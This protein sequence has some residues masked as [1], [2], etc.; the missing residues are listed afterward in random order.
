VPFLEISDCFTPP[1][2]PLPGSARN[3]LLERTSCGQPTSPLA[4]RPTGRLAPPARRGVCMDTI[5]IL[6]HGSNNSPCEHQHNRLTTEASHAHHTFSCFLR[7]SHKSLADTTA[8]RPSGCIHKTRGPCLRCRQGGWWS[9]LADVS[10]CLD[11]QT[12]RLREVI[13]AAGCR[14]PLDLRRKPKLNIEGD[15]PPFYG[16]EV[17]SRC[18]ILA[19]AGRP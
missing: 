6:F 5:A 8:R 3:H 7:T 11:T 14:V 12:K 10:R 16:Q 4:D 19:A 2:I 15:K 1:G 18:N 9:V 17:S 13:L